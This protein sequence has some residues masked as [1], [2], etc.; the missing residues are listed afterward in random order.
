MQILSYNHLVS[1][2]EIYTQI[3]F[4]SRHLAI[5]E[6]YMQVSSYLW[7]LYAFWTQLTMLTS[8]NATAKF[9]EI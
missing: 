4:F 8:G 6:N 1:F 3:I 5:S 7:Q 9:F 2:F